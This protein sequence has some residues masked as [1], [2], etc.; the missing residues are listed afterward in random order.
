M[1]IAAM[2][3]PRG[4][5]HC[6]LPSFSS[7]LSLSPVNFANDEINQSLFREVVVLSLSSTLQSNHTP[8]HS[9]ATSCLMIQEHPHGPKPKYT[10]Q[11]NIDVILDLVDLINLSA[12]VRI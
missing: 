11:D 7:K 12:S 3:L 5:K 1:N 2:H 8:Y 4:T 6:K 9:V 10:A